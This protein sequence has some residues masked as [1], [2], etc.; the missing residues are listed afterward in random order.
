MR[1]RANGIFTN[2]FRLN[3]TVK[4]AQKQRVQPRLE[5]GVIERLKIDGAS[6]A[7][8]TLL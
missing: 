1:K 5:R 2:T 8:S 7:G 4:Q 6:Q 3:W